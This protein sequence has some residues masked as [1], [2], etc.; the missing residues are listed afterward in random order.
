MFLR[1]LT[2]SLKGQDEKQYNLN[3][4]LATLDLWLEKLDTIT[5]SGE[6]QS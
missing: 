4:F 1:D 6:D 2:D 5:G 3:E